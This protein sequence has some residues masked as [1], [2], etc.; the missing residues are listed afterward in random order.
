MD[1][2]ICAYG[3]LL[4]IV[5]ESVEAPCWKCSPKI[6][7]LDC[8]QVDLAQ[9]PD[10]IPRVRFGIHKLEFHWLEAASIPQPQTS[11]IFDSPTFLFWSSHIGTVTWLWG[12]VHLLDISGQQ[13]SYLRAEHRG[14]VEVLTFHVNQDMTRALRQQSVGRCVKW[15]PNRS[16]CQPVALAVNKCKGGER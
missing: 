5:A 1:H 7:V 15:G 3:S 14:K 16:L 8:Y 9:S 10:R 12:F 2:Q 6:F 11:F 4:C 13:S